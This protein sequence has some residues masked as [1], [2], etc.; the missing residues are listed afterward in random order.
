MPFV[1]PC[2]NEV[3]GELYGSL[4]KTHRASFITWAV[5]SRFA[6]TVHVLCRKKEHQKSDGDKA[7]KKLPGRSINWFLVDES[8]VQYLAVE[9]EN[10]QNPKLSLIHI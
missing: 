7:D 4:C 6:F 10:N 2:P 5:A 9:G 8:G 1:T 3:S